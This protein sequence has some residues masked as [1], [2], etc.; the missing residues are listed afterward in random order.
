MFYHYTELP[1]PEDSIKNIESKVGEAS[2]KG[3]NSYSLP[4]DLRP[5]PFLFRHEVPFEITDDKLGKII[6]C[7]LVESHS[8]RTHMVSNELTKFPSSYKPS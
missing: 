2:R 6:R 1:P 8:W 7:A 3:S 5:E 4:H